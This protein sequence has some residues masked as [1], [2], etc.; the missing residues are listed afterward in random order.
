MSL[1]H[2]IRKLEEGAAPGGYRFLVEESDDRG[3]TGYRSGA[4]FFPVADDEDANACFRRASRVVGGSVVR[5][6][7]GD[8]AL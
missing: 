1:E 8:L 2:R 4:Q 6:Y 3:V 5:C 7:P